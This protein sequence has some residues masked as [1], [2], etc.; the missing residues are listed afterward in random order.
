MGEKI[1]YFGDYEL[2][3]EIG[4]GAMGV[5]YRA[6]QVSLNRFVAIKTML[7]D[8][9]RVGPEQARRFQTEAEAAACLDHPN[10]VP[11]HEVG[12][13]DGYS[14]LSM[15][16]VEGGNLAQW[17][18]ATRDPNSPKSGYLHPLRPEQKSTQPNA[19]NHSNDGMESP[20]NTR[21]FEFPSTPSARNR[22][23]ATLMAGIARAVHH[24]HQ[25]GVLHRDLKPENILLD[26][27]GEPYVTD[28]GLAKFA[29]SQALLSQNGAVLGTPAYMAP[30]QA[31]N[32]REATTASD[33]YGLGAVLYHL[34]AGRPPFHGDSLN[35]VL[36]QVECAE[37]QPLS[38]ISSWV[39]PNLAIICQKCLHKKPS[40]RYLSAAEFANDLERLLRG[41]PIQA[42]QVSSSERLWLWC[43]RRPW[44]A[45]TIVTVALA[46]FTIGFLQWRHT[47]QVS[48]LNELLSRSFSGAVIQGAESSFRFGESSEAVANLAKQARE[49]PDSRPITTRLLSAL[50]WRDWPLPIQAFGSNTN[51]ITFAAFSAD[52]RR[53]VAR[54][55]GGMIDVWDLAS[56]RRV[57][58]TESAPDSTIAFSKTAGWFAT[59]S[60]SQWIR[61]I[62]VEDGKISSFQLPPNT[63]GLAVSTVGSLFATGVG[64]RLELRSFETGQRLKAIPLLPRDTG[65]SSPTKTDRNVRV[66]F[67]GDGSR[68]FGID[69]ERLLVGEVAT[70]R[71]IATLLLDSAQVEHAFSD[72]K[73]NEVV[74]ADATEVVRIDVSRQARI[75]EVTP[76]GTIRNLAWDSAT[77]QV[78]VVIGVGHHG[79]PVDTVLL[80]G[81]TGRVLQTFQ[82]GSGFTG[83]DPFSPD[84]GRILIGKRWPT[85]GVQSLTASS[86]TSEPIHAARSMETVEFSPDGFQVLISDH[87]P[88][89]SLYD[90]RPGRARPFLFNQGGLVVA[91]QASRSG[92]R[93][94]TAS[95]NG[96]ARLWDVHT[97]RPL[98]PELRQASPIVC[99]ALDPDG[100]RAATGSANGEIVLWDPTR[101]VPL[102]GPIRVAGRPLRMAF[103]PDGQV[104]AILSDKLGF[105]I[106]DLT[107][108]TPLTPGI[109]LDEAGSAGGHRVDAVRFDQSGHRVLVASGRG[110]FVW[111]LKP[112]RQLWRT[113]APAFD[114]AFSPDGLHVAVAASMDS[115]VSILSASTGQTL[116][117]PLSHPDFTVGVGFDPKAELLAATSLDPLVLLWST[118]TGQLV[119]R[120]SGHTSGVGDVRFSQDGRM[121]S[122]SSD[123]SIRI[124]DCELGLPLS[125][126]LTGHGGTSVSVAE[127][128]DGDR[129]LLAFSRAS[130][131][132]SLWPCE[133]PPLPAPPWLAD[134]A[135]LLSGGDL[136]DWRHRESTHVFRLLVLREKLSQLP[137]DDFYARWARWFFADRATRAPFPE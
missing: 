35:E 87:A 31:R 14:Y 57:G 48:T 83:D 84:G 52:G 29:G 113:T 30:E 133:S 2:L 9:S 10:I 18:K 42:R 126:P 46:V 119:R 106:Q 54:D 100:R 105:W 40:D 69:R 129:R 122:A 26:A 41:E 44:V 56:S 5:V 15:K 88:F 125:E 91:Y 53:V 17:R 21:P 92:D 25:R 107:T 74:L 97:T 77:E 45:G 90:V 124:W 111:G 61:A 49:H 16:L 131:G 81:R 11:V 28:F 20:T 32:S 19:T 62:R 85:I 36:R 65:I 116:I 95:T 55:A 51:S 23:I 76:G 114:A 132:L 130:K 63:T 102:P 24:A 120:L 136:G 110:V 96:V 112:A 75:W 70:G 50:T 134:L 98:G 33:V 39:D 68:V 73:G 137:G 108:D 60:T 123:N 47:G 99:V 7:M 4:R 93:V 117:G 135:E 103:S 6:R 104:L 1:P 22:A 34:I 67:S 78:A 37:P 38:R 71:Q 109:S 82:N 128:A 43:L 27:A 94:L 86:D 59:V 127:F 66:L 12:T 101:K 72:S 118:K 3:G 115:Q 58:G 121:T 64:D 80:E 13:H 79:G 8:V 89:A